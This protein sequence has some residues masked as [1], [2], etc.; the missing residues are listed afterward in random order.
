MNA[1]TISH[2]RGHVA[3]LREDIQTDI[4][5]LEKLPELSLSQRAERLRSRI[6]ARQIIVADLEKLI[7]EWGADR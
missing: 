4:E 2:L 5:R 1:I 7:E 3:Q 6:N